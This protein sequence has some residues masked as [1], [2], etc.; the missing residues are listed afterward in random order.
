M[1]IT[2]IALDNS[3]MTWVFLVL[4]TFLGFSV[5]NNFPSKE[6]PSIRINRALV[7]TQF[8]GLPPEQVENLISKKLEE[9]LREIGELKNISST[10]ITG[11]SIITID[12][13][14][15]LPDFDKVWDKVRRKVEDTKPSLPSGIYGPTM[16]DDFGDVAIVT[17]ALTGD[18]WAMDELRDHARDIRDR[19]YTVDGIR[20]VSLYGVQEEKVYLEALPSLAEE[21]SIDI[22]GAMQ[23][24]QDQNTILP[25]GKIYTPYRE[26]T[27]ETSGKL[28]SI[29][30]LDNIEIKT[31]DGEGTLAI[32]DYLSIRQSFS[33]PPNDLAFYNGKPSI[34]IAA[35]MQHGRNILEVGPRLKEMLTDLDAN[36]PVGMELT[37]ATFQPDVVGKSINDVKNS[38]YQTLVI[39][40]IVVIIALGLVEG[41]IVGVTVPVTILATLLVMFFMEIDLQFI[42][43]A[44]LIIGLGM[45]VDNGIVITENIHLRLNQ[46]AKKYDAAIDACKELAIPLLTSTLTTVLAFAPILIAEGTTGEYT[47]SLAQ[48][49]SISLLISWV[50][51]LTVVP[52]LAVRFIPNKHQE[53]PFFLIGIYQRIIDKVLAFPKA[54]MGLVTGIFVFSLMIV[55]LV[56]VEMFA[57]SSRTEVLVYLDVPAGYNVH[58]TTQATQKLTS[59]LKDENQNPE[60]DY[61]SSYIGNGGPRFFLSISP[62]NPAPNRSFTIVNTASASDAKA[63]VNKIKRFSAE[64]MPT[65]KVRPQLIAR[66]TV[67]PGVV[68][69]RF[70]GP[71][72]DTLYQMALT[73]EKALA[74]IPGAED[75]TNDWQNKS[76]RF[77]VDIDQAKVRRAGIT[78][79]AISNALN[80]VFTGGK[81][82]DIRRGDTLIPVIV[83]LKGD[84]LG[85]EDVG[86][87]LDKV[88][89]F[90]SAN[91]HEYV[92][93]SQVA[94]IKVVPQFGSIIRRNM[95]KTITI[96]GRHKVMRAPELQATWDAKI[97][98]IYNNLPKGYSIELGGELE[99][100]SNSAGTLFLTLPL[101]FGLIFCI[102]VAQF[103]SFRKTGIVVMTIPLAFSGGFLGLFITGANFDF[104]GALGFL[105]LA[106]IIINNAIVLIDKVSAEL[107]TGLTKYE[108]IKS[109]S[110]NRLRPILITTATTILALI[111][112]MLMEETLFYS[113]ASVIIF[114]LA[115]G[116]IM[117][118][119]AVPALCLL[120]LKEPENESIAQSNQDASLTV[121]T[122]G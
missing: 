88:K 44:S 23:A 49:V 117:T 109:A 103:A 27:V 4:I 118:L 90:T 105:S 113:M 83:K 104:I 65:A 18:G 89:I 98:D 95:D 122:S 112:L 63:L 81:V 115:I 15:D 33:E 7:I 43:L 69:L 78:Y 48:V 79:Q 35:S 57:T 94:T 41:L 21:Q 72:A 31:N 8:P 12:A 121:A 52:L 2:K 87:L 71:D 68:Q 67:P 39:V 56:P 25:S 34:V 13:H 3:R 51:S 97:Q 60:V 29:D 10:S 106:G 101:F 93:L 20:R 62:S 26:I 53:K 59:W 80:G 86:H 82:T 55:A 107:T 99:G 114:G 58:Q 22:A 116:T 28:N 46:G 77:Q 108:A 50:L 47:R 54:F 30:D 24:I 61:V 91:K 42:S 6:D 19:I 11:Q 5:Y 73:A 74:S 92:L 32:K 40:L 14:E 16:N 110:L 38:L 70:S 100:F 66:G 64:N 84:N 102:L 119:G 9:R 75:V 17:A 85:N 36:L 120:F 76:K 1:S 37:V 96:G 45:L 111:P